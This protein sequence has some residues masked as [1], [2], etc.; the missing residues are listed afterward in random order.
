[1]YLR[2]VSRITSPKQVRR[3]RIKT[4]RS[5][6]ADVSN[7]TPPHP[8]RS[9]ALGLRL[10]IHSLSKA[11]AIVNVPFVRRART[12]GS[13]RRPGR[14]RWAVAPPGWRAAAPSSSS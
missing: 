6:K 14:G 10:M 13:V 12:W 3:E 7:L 1:M 2:G 8:D 5:N 4:V 11:N 9:I